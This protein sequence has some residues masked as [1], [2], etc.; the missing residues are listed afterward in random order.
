MQASSSVCLSAIAAIEAFLLQCP[1]CDRLLPL[2]TLDYRTSA[3]HDHEL[4]LSTQSGHRMYVKAGVQRFR[5]AFGSIITV[6]VQ[7]AIL[8]LIV[9]IALRG[10]LEAC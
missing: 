6:T 1:L 8:A 7:F 10:G 2:R 5:R 9:D 3:F 4:T